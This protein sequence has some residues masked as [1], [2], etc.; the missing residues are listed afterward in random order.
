[1]FFDSLSLG[2]DTQKIQIQH[3]GKVDK[4]AIKDQ[5]HVK[6]IYSTEINK[7]ITY[8]YGVTKVNIS[9]LNDRSIYKVKPN[10][11]YIGA[12]AIRNSLGS[13]PVSNLWLAEY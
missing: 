4:P 10:Q 2:S 1:M 8:I 11:N 3:R 13:I 6:L 12:S 7:H 9:T 5:T